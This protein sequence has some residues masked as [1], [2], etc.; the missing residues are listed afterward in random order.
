MDIQKIGKLLPE[1]PSPRLLKDTILQKSEGALG[2]EFVVFHRESVWVEPH[3]DSAY[4]EKRWGAACHCTAC[5]NDFFAGYVSAT[6]SGKC[7][8]GIALG[9]GDD[10][11]LYEGY[12]YVEDNPWDWV[13]EISRF[14]TFQCPICDN[15]VQ[16]VHRSDIRYG[17]T[18][19]LAVASVENVETYT[20]LITW[21]VRRRLNEYGYWEKSVL[22]R[23]AL[24]IDETGR[25]HRYTHTKGGGICYGESQLSQWEY[26]S[27]FRDGFQRKY[28]NYDSI[29]H[30]L[31]GGECWKDIPDLSGTTGEKTGLAEYMRSGG[32]WPQ[33]YLKLWHTHPN[34]ENLLKAGWFLLIEN[35][36]CDVLETKHG[37]YGKAFLSCPHI[38]GVNFNEVK[39][40][41]MLGITKE[42]VKTLSRRLSAKET[43]QEFVRW[44]EG[45]QPISATEFAD[46]V[47][48]FGG[49]ETMEQLHGLYNDFG[50]EWELRETLRYVRRHKEMRPKDVVDTLLDYRNMLRTAH[51]RRRKFTQTE[52]WPVA[53]RRHH[54][55]LAETI[56][57]QNE[58]NAALQ[59]QQGFQKI[60]EAYGD[61]EWTDGEL[62]IRLPRDNG[63]L[64]REGTVLR[65]CVGSYGNAHIERRDV[66]FFVRKYRRPE[67]CYYTLDINMQGKPYEKQLHGYGNEHHGKN[68]E[69][70]HSI[71]PKVRAFVDRWETE[72]LLPWYY[73]QQRKD[74]KS[75]KGEN[76]A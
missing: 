14:E 70:T 44:R 29:C 76:V 40:H 63:E 2:G 71:P 7:V 38:A 21:L 74:R 43:F 33:M 6:R 66:I 35:C 45:S 41:K 60:L 69:H 57:I 62:C 26:R 49:E 31:L 42:E 18:Y 55:T 52:L 8:A 23:E 73:E 46:L 9:Q 75:K 13:S 64:L 65:H 47:A 67:R 17:H 54:D 12:P 22:P 53:L 11:Q 1:A 16:L 68:K 56:R 48:F 4:R 30:Q 20:A 25:L 36:I 59:Y 34:V 37:Y 19:Q 32:G 15:F 27:G 61:L 28:Y 24:V 50:E 5:E 39:P 72:V 51:P 58:K 3:Y 10:G